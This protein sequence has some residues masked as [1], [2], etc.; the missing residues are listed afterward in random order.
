MAYTFT[1]IITSLPFDY[2]IKV[3]F[4]RDTGTG[5]LTKTNGG[6]IGDVGKITTGIDS[7]LG[8]YK[9]PSLT[10]TVRNVENFYSGTLFAGTWNS[11]DL[12]IW[13]SYDAGTTYENLFFGRILPMTL[14]ETHTASE[15]TFTRLYEFTA[16]SSLS[17]LSSV[18]VDPVGKPWT[19]V[20]ETT[21]NV[22]GLRYD[23]AFFWNGTTKRKWIYFTD[24]L[25]Q[26]FGYMPCNSA[27]TVLVDTTDLE[28]EFDN[29][30]NANTY[31]ISDLA[32]VFNDPATC[33]VL[34]KASNVDGV[35]VQ[36]FANYFDMLKMLCES[37]NIIPLP[38][39]W[40]N[41]ATLTLTIHLRH[42][43]KDTV[44]GI[45]G[46]LPGERSRSKEI[47]INVSS[48]KVTTDGIGTAYLG[49]GSGGGQQVNV[50][51]GIMSSQNCTA[52]YDTQYNVI[53]ATLDPYYLDV[54]Y[55]E[56]SNEEYPH[57]RQMF[58]GNNAE[59][60]MIHKVKL[61]TSQAFQPGTTDSFLGLQDAVGLTMDILTPSW[62]TI[63]RPMYKIAVRSL[64]S[65]GASGTVFDFNIIRKIVI[66][67]HDC[68]I[69]SI[70]R[71]PGK[72]LSEITAIQIEL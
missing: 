64:K 71:N 55:I 72:N 16:V 10:M 22:P 43:Y 54:A 44:V 28:I 2:Y 59:L 23:G 34:L 13:I 36:G 32:F 17:F 3:E 19:P 61:R 57:L 66:D 69:L 5:T 70:D 65:N 51:C 15:E 30:N 50:Q 60:L 29:L 27:L 63:G 68:M 26:I 62:E 18:A 6:Y 53:N 39:F 11:I 41:G 9:L 21:Q 48:I 47:G 1:N 24:I 7:R 33:Y 42:R 12:R 38:R 45:S 37:L 4:I 56:G 8:E 49:T 67:G 14:R 58:I 25:F 31:N 35:A 40:M 20:Q 46:T 52:Y